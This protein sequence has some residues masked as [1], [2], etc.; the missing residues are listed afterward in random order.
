MTLLKKLKRLYDSHYVDTII[1]LLI[2]FYT[3]YFLW[4]VYPA[5]HI[6]FGVLSKECCDC[7]MYGLPLNLTAP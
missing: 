5:E 2:L 3:I 1:L 4:I 7:A 6:E